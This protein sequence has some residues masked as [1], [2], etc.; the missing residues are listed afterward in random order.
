MVYKISVLKG[1]QIIYTTTARSY[2]CY[3]NILAR[4]RSFSEIPARWWCIYLAPVDYR[5]ASRQHRSQFGPEDLRNAIKMFPTCIQKV[6]NMAASMLEPLLR[7]FGYVFMAFG[8]FLGPAWSRIF[9]AISAKLGEQPIERYR[10]KEN[11]ANGKNLDT[12]VASVEQA[13]NIRQQII[14]HSPPNI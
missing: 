5:A 11:T 3:R 14:Q 9:E 4:W 8:L 10:R 12:T 1:T 7:H 2:F 13:A 6:S